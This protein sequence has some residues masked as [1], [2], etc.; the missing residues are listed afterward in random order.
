MSLRIRIVGAG[1]IRERFWLDAM[2]EYQKRLS[3]YARVE[4]VAVADEPVPERVSAA[5]AAAIKE[6]EGQRLLR[7]MD[8]G[9]AVVALDL[10]GATMSSEAFAAW[11]AE[12]AVAGQGSFA[13]VV[14]G[15]LGLADSVLARADLRLSLGPM[16]FPHQMVPLL[17][18]EQIYRACRIN[19]G[20]PYHR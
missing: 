8:P 13:F 20:E 6:R 15:T 3:A 1:K 4:V 7:A 12:R 18:L 19:A 9:Q 14:G 16:T 5:E 2:A 10:R 17:L 11:L